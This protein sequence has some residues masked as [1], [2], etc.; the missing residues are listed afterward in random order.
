MTNIIATWWFAVIVMATPA[1]D[2]TFVH[3]PKPYY[4]QHQCQSFLIKFREENKD[5]LILDAHCLV[6]TPG[7]DA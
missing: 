6:V 7:E 4:K 5:K 1:G 2:I 3:T